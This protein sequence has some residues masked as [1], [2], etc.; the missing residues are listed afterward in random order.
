MGTRVKTESCYDEN[1]VREYLLA[2]QQSRQDVDRIR[3]NCGNI[4]V[5]GN[6][7]SCSKRGP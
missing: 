4:C 3:N 7:E 6:P 1:Q 5:C 2:L